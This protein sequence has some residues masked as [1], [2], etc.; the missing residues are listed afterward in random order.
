MTKNERQDSIIA[1]SV[2]FAVALLLLLF[3]FFGGMTFD[4]AQLAQASVPEIQADDD[5]LFIEPEILQ[6]LG[7]ENAVT[8]NAPA[9]AFKGLPQQA[10]EENTKLVVPGKNENPA[11]PV[12]KPVTSTK[13]NPIKAADPPKTSEEKKIVTSKMADKFPGQNGSASGTSGTSGAGGTGVGISGSVSGRTF[14]GCPRPS[15]E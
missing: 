9:P 7:E 3:L 8:Q 2:T 15:V 1:A 4:R 14:K 12:E 11:P 6:D 13:E 5:E 10:E